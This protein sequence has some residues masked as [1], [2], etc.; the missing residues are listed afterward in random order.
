MAYSKA[1][2]AT[3]IAALV[4]A[5]ALSATASDGSSN[6]SPMPYRPFPSLD[7][8]A[9]K[10][11]TRTTSFSGTTLDNPCTAVP[12]AISVDGNMQL[13]TYVGTMADGRSRVWLTET[14]AIQ[15]TDAVGNVTY[16]SGSSTD[17]VTYGPGP[18]TL[19]KYKKMNTPDQFHAVFVMDFNP[20]TGEFTVTL[21]ADC[22]NGL[23]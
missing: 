13:T 16:A 12:E 8:L 4:A 21:Q 9:V 7:Y 18:F 1:V 11:T 22:S 20:V 5:A 17:D 10:S 23:P 2:L 3:C 15:G 14:T 6:P 19:L